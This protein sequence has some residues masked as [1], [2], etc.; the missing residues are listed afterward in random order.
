MRSKDSDISSISG[1]ALRDFE[2]PE[3]FGI[4]KVQG[5]TPL[6]AFEDDVAALNFCYEDGITDSAFVRLLTQPGSQWKFCFSPCP[7]AA[8]SIHGNCFEGSEHWGNIAVPCSWECAGH[9]QAT[10][11]NFQYPFK[12]DP[13]RIPDAMNH[14]GSYQTSFT[15]PERWCAGRRIWI[16]FEGVSSAFYCWVNGQLVGY[17]QDSRLPAEFD[18]TSALL[19]CGAA[20]ARHVLAVRV[21]RFCDGSYLEDQVGSPCARTAHLG[22]KVTKQAARRTNGG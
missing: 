18:I 16:M 21:Y 13:P 20:D 11:T 15:V 17:S 4:N 10:Y 5:H 3:V 12:V 9:G 2:N 8:P 6:F 14:V 22:G 19:R 1:S 7:S